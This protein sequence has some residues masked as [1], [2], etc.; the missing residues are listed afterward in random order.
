MDVICYGLSLPIADNDT[1]K[2]CVTVYCDW[3][4]ALLPLPNVTVPR[5]IVEDAN[6][7]ARK[8]INHFHNLFVPRPGEGR[9]GLVVRYCLRVVF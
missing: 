8:I 3:L 6:L 2:D 4:S 9:T 7:Y 1:I 5:P